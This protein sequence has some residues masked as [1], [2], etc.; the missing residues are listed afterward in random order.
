MNPFKHILLSLIA[1]LALFSCEKELGYDISSAQAVPMLNAIW[2]AG[3]TEH[4]VYLCSSLPYSVSSL[5][6]G[7]RITCYVNGS[8]V[9]ETDQYLD[10]ISRNKIPF[11][12][13]ILRANLS[14]GD[15]VKLVAHI[16]G[17]EITSAS[18]V[19][20]AASVQMDTN[21][22]D[23]SF[24]K[25]QDDGTVLVIENRRIY[26][27]KMTLKDISG[28]PTYYRLHAPSV[29][30]EIRKSKNNEVRDTKDWAW[31][32]FDEKDPL[33]KNLTV[34]FPYELT[35]EFPFLVGTSN[36][37]HVFSDD[38]FKDDSYSFGFGLNQDDYDLN[39]WHREYADIRVHFRLS[40]LTRDM[41]LYLLATNAAA[42]AA[43][44]PL[45]EPVILPSN[46]EGGL[47]FF[48]IENGYDEVIPLKKCYYF[49][50]DL[51]RYWSD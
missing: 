7:S 29:H 50:P 13:Y 32:P 10:E 3:D 36:G 31:L 33:F 16:N 47:G 24:I 25:K 20:F 44:D 27:F 14:G 51:E 37:T 46:V 45:S 19:P 1:L 15:Y 22:I 23:N 35:L 39:V 5:T 48:G 40:T 43:V 34:Q 6:E 21:S 4:S 2:N 30:S 17:K 49:D 38:L 8:L 12:K 18:M 28:E 41:Y 9:D 42:S 11:Q 26:S